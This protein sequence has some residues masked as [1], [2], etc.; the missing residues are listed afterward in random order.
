[1]PVFKVEIKAL[2]EGTHVLSTWKHIRRQ[3]VLERVLEEVDSIYPAVCRIKLD[4]DKKCSS[5]NSKNAHLRIVT[6]VLNY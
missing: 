6:L 4:A 3:A 2:F 5:Q 1:M